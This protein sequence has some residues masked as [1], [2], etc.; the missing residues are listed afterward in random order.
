MQLMCR[1]ADHLGL[2]SRPQLTQFYGGRK[3]LPEHPWGDYY[4]HAVLTPGEDKYSRQVHWLNR[5]EAE[6]RKLLDEDEIGKIASSQ[7]SCNSF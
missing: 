3:Q 4:F 5:G 2:P 7:V 6:F 1:L